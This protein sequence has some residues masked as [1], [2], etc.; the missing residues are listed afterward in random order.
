[1]HIEITALDLI[2]SYDY[3]HEGNSNRVLEI[4]QEYLLAL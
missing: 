2:V 3:I 4:G 1:M